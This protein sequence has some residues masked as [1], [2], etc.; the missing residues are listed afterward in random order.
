MRDRQELRGQ[1]LHS[2]TSVSLGHVQY[3][4]RGIIFPVQTGFFSF[5]LVF[6]CCLCSWICASQLRVRQGATAL[7]SLIG[8]FYACDMNLALFPYSQEM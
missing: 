8:T 2:P 3:F 5:W 6:A 7:G 4:I 1:Q